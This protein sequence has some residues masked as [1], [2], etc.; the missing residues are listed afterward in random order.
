MFEFNICFASPIWLD[1]IQSLASLVAIPGAIAAF[2]KL[3]KK[4]EQLEDAI[5]EIKRLAVASETK[6]GIEAEKRDLLVEHLDLLRAIVLKPHT[7]NPDNAKLVELEERK[8]LLSLR[9]RLVCAGVKSSGSSI[10]PWIENHGESAFLISAEDIADPPI[11]NIL[12]LPNNRPEIKNSGFFQIHCKRKDGLNFNAQ[13][14]DM[15]IRIKY[16]DKEGNLYE[17]LLEGQVDKPL[18]MTDPKLIMRKKY[19]T[20]ES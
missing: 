12:K 10:T 7:S 8:H 1:L 13:M 16:E 11:L 4:D 6:A 14:R 5:T 15:I 20:P 9:P 3:F 18:T 17:Q 2:Y 19:D